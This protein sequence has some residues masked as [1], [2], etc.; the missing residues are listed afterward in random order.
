MQLDTLALS[1][2]QTE[3]QVRYLGQ[4]LR[5]ASLPNVCLSLALME[6]L[7]VDLTESV[8]KSG[9]KLSFLC[10]GNFNVCNSSRSYL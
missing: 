9:G 3:Q 8:L 1:G 5:A 2:L 7:I 4:H 6:L 10:T